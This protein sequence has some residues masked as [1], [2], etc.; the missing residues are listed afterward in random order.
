MESKLGPAVAAERGDAVITIAIPT[1]RRF[2][3]LADCVWSALSGTVRP[4]RVLIIDNSG[5]QC[6]PVPGAEIVQGRQPQSVAKAWNDAA[7]LAGGDH[8]ILSNDDIVFAPDTIE[9]MLAVA[10]SVPRAGIVSPI[11]GQRFACFLLR[12]TAYLDV[13]PFDE[14]FLGAYF[15]DNDY[16]WRLECAGWSLPIAPS[17]VRH[18]GS[19]TIRAMTP[20]QLTEK[21]RC[22]AHNE[23]LYQRKWGGPPHQERWTVPFGERV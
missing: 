15:E 17:D 6:P 7:Q 1:L 2:D 16:A 19:A 20:A 9:R 11:E 21:H 23:R 14:A 5:G 10:A 18:A 8:L 22:Y 4:D 13:G 3:L 12:W